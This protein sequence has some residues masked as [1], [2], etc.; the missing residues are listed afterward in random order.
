MALIRCA[1][2]LRSAMPHVD[3]KNILLPIIIFKRISDTYHDEIAKNA[4]TG[5]EN[6]HRYTIPINCSWYEILT[7]RYDISQKLEP[8]LIAIETANPQLEGILVDRHSRLLVED[9]YLQEVAV[10]GAECNTVIEL[11]LAHH[12]A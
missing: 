2:I 6:P 8:A 12:A 4:F 3:Y 7:T 10:A 5:L 1:K 11:T 9:K